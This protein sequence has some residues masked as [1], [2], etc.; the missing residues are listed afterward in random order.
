MLASVAK[1]ESFSAVRF[2]YFE[3]ELREKIKPNEKQLPR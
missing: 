1:K 3:I 2:P